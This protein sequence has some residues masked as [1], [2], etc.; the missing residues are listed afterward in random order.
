MLRNLIKIRNM[1]KYVKEPGVFC[2]LDWWHAREAFEVHKTYPRKYGV[3]PTP[4][5]KN[6]NEC[7]YSAFWRDRVTK[8]IWIKLR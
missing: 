5:S 7:I 4:I 1:E 2:N 6:F 3:T 8:K